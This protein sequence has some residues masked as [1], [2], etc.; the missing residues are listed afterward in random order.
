MDQIDGWMALALAQQQDIHFIPN[1]LLSSSGRPIPVVIAVWSVSS[2][3]FFIPVVS[4]SSGRG[5]A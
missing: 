2:I 4:V 1:E 3:A 5:M